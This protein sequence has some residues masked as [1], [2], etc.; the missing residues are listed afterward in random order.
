MSKQ[1]GR[2]SQG[3][4]DFLAPY[5]PTIGTATD[6]GTARPYNNGSA[7]VTF[8]ATGPNTADSFT[9]Y[10][11][12]DPTKTASGASSPLTVTGLASATN[13]TFKVYGTN[14]AGGRGSDSAASNQITAT[15]VPQAPSLGAIT[16][17]CSARA[18]NNGLVTVAMTAN[19]TGGK[20]ISGYYAV[21]NGGQ[22]A[23]SASSPVSVTGLLSATNYT[24]QGRVSNANGNSELTASSSAVTV[25]TVPG[26]VTAVSASS[27]SAGVDR[28][29]WTAP[30]N[31]GSA[32]T[33]YNWVSSDG[34]S[35]S[36][37]ATSIDIS[38][39]Q[40]TAQTYTVTAVNACGAGPASGASNSI[41]TTFSFVPFGVFG[42]SP[43]GV[44]SFSPFGVFSFSPFGFSPFGVFGFSPFGFSPFGFSP[45]GFSPFG[46]SPFSFSPSGFSFTPRFMASL[47]P[48]TKVRMA[49]GS[50]K[51]AEDVYVGDVLMS[52]ELPEFANSYTTEELMAWTSTQDIADLTL[53]T[54]TVNKVT[55]H[56]SDKVI[57]V[58]EDV[59]S[60]NHLILIKRDATV[61]MCRA[62]NLTPTDLIW[63]YSTN[64]W[65]EISVLEMHDYDHT[66][67][68]INCEPN[69]LFFTHSALTHDGNEW[70]PNQA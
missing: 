1:A 15:T 29:I 12:E 41:T 6:V 27:P 36:T 10:A 66:V 62:D 31:G 60:P 4:N 28:L 37:A 45:F 17:S 55:I 48:M 49:D 47:A 56:P 35:G 43:F 22:N 25:T 57:S 59:F 5:A 32:I 61:F 68:T 39:E 52:V 58:N 51:A 23:S 21:S 65:A 46:F 63:D 3:A 44:F 42:F 18:L 16:V 13:Y 67:I 26:Q 7:T 30:S 53:T 54:T 20:A 70:N 34:K 38:Q 8:T 69:D 40:G 24:F 19:A 14:T 9:V 50:M 64:G 2:M 33:A 11:V